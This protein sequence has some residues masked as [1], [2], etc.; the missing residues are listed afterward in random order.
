M[1]ILTIDLEE[2]FHILN[3]D[4][5]NYKKYKRIEYNTESLIELLKASNTKATFF[6][7][8]SLA[9]EYKELITLL[10][11]DF[12]IGIHGFSH[13]PLP[14]LTNKEIKDDILRAKNT[15]E[16]I[17][18]KKVS[19]YRAP[20]FSISNIETFNI[21]AQCGIDVD[22]S[23]SCLNHFYGKKII[24]TD[25]PLIISTKYGDIKELPPSAFNVCGLKGFL[26][27]G[28]FRIMPYN[29][30]KYLSKKKNNNLVF[31]IHPR[32]IDKEQPKI[33]ELSLF[34][35]Y[36]AY[37]GL[38]SSKDKLKKYLQE[39]DFVDINTAINNIDWQKVNR[40]NLP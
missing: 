6:V 13:Q 16:E 39:F 2:W 37:V 26:G 14:L 38:N 29:L 25:Q 30:I 31:Y 20:G 12:D 40:I 5:S 19:K 7:L 21:L 27:G 33:K 17:I 32:D 1:N 11:K 28:Y 18:H 9:K 10:S 23:A 36:K 3:F 22:S 8:V 15:I 34:Q 24:N 35:K 4:Y